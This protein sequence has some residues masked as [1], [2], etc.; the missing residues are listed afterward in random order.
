VYDRLTNPSEYT[1]VYK[2]AW[3]AGGYATMNHG[4]DIGVTGSRTSFA[5]HTNT[6]TNE[7]IHDIRHTLRT[8]A[9]KGKAFKP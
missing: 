5:G 9:A 7:V 4:A 2:R 8:G 6:A 1:G 3:H